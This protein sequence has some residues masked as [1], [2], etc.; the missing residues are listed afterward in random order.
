[1]KL[2]FMV[3]GAV[4]KERIAQRSKE[5]AKKAVAYGQ[6]ADSGVSERYDDPRA[7]ADRNIRRVRTLEWISFCLE[8]D[9]MYEVDF[10]DIERLDRGE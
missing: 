2:S 6:M 5:F 8:D 10:E 4:L 1:M 7:E 3:S 9:T